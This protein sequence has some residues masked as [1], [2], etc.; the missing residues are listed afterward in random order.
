[1]WKQTAIFMSNPALWGNL[2]SLH[3]S[4]KLWILTYIVGDLGSIHTCQGPFGLHFW[5]TSG[6][7]VY[8]FV[9]FGSHIHLQNLL[10]QHTFWWSFGSNIHF[11]ESWILTYI[12]GN[13]WFSCTLSGNL[14]SSCTF[15]ELWVPT[16]IQ[17]RMRCVR[18]MQS[19][20]ATSPASI[21]LKMFRIILKYVLYWMEKSLK[22]T[23]TSSC[24][25]FPNSN[26]FLSFFLNLLFRIHQRSR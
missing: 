3:T 19:F 6:P 21:Y 10:F 16:N 5:G 20:A 12:L 11:R 1:M 17:I 22:L 23:W 18:C 7:H 4:W 14:W 26:N 2:G 9:S 13:L 24:N 15:W 8:F 25:K